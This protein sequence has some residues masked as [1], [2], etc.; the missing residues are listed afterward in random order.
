MPMKLSSSLLRQ[1][2]PLIRLSALFF[3]LLSPSCAQAQ[4]ADRLSE[5][6]RIA[7]D[8]VGTEKLPTAIRDRVIQRLKASSVV[9][10]FPD[11]SQ[12]DAILHAM[13]EVWTTGYVSSSPRSKSV[14]QPSYQGFA[15][16]EL[17]GRG[18]KTLWSYLVTPRPVGWKSITDDLSDQL[19]HAFL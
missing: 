16:A 7:I 1:L 9:E 19:V 17:T 11:A 18:G 12:P 2:H 3:V 14:E 4:N 10:V 15:S 13:A 5:V 6:K 8:W